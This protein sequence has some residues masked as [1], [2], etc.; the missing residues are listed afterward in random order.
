MNIHR[1]LYLENQ[2]YTFFSSVHKTFAETD[3]RCG[4]KANNFPKV[5][6]V[7]ITFCDQME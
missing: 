5:E 2:E 1:N 6:I 4:H 7:Q 3:I